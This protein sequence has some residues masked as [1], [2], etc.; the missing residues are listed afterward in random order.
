MTEFNAIVFVRHQGENRPVGRMKFVED[1]RFSRSEFA[2]GKSWLEDPT[3]FAID[4][5]QLP[6]KSGVFKTAPDFPLFNGIRDSAPDAW[7]RRVIDAIFKAKHGRMANEAEYLFASQCGNRA[8]ALMFGKDPSGPSPVIDI[9]LPAISHD[10][11]SLAKL[12]EAADMLARGEEIDRT[13]AFYLAPGSEMGGARPKATLDHNGKPALVKFGTATD[14]IDMGRVE[15]GCLDLC[16]MV[17]LPVPDRDVVD[18]AGRPAL[19]LARFDRTPKDGYLPERR[20]MISSMTL[21]GA[22][23]YDREA[24]GYADLVD[25]MRIHG[26]KGDMENL[27]EQIY[28]RMVANVCIG[29]T[30]D[31]Y[32]NHAYLISD[33]G[34]YEMSPVYDVTPSLQVSSSRSMFFALGKAGT[35]REARLDHAIAA[36]PAFG[37]KPERAA[38]I[39]TTVAETIALNWEVVMTNRGVSDTDIE[40]IRGSFS[41]CHNRSRTNEID[42][43]G[44]VG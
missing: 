7:G 36:G 30:D 3:A 38:E 41:E 32:R 31:H 29:N 22:H 5:V 23:E 43:E 18:I 42:I 8:G 13:Y 27:S 26:A 33:D 1:G 14:R 6:L 15:A 10:G 17:G 19:V 44:L 25:A 11:S 24:N 12:Q 4:P 35:G 21:L 28:T 34:R 2:Y 16:E 37:L 39:A 20:H 9:V 40:A